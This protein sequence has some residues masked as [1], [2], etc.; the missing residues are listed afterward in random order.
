MMLTE[1]LPDQNFQDFMTAIAGNNEALEVME[2]ILQ[3]FMQQQ[4]CKCRIMLSFFPGSTV[5]QCLTQD[6]G[7]AGSSLTGVTA[8]CS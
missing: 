4:N 8:L 2:Y 6:R 7:A 3:G 1:V 5:A